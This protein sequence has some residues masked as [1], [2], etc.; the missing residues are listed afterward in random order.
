MSN[1]TPFNFQGSEIR[2]VGTADKPEWVAADII[3][4]LYPDVRARD[5]ANYLRRIPEEWKGSTQVYDSGENHREESNH[6]SFMVSTKR[7]SPSNGQYRNMVTVTEPGLYHLIFRSDSPLAVPFQRWV[8]EDVLPS[9][10]K[11]GG[12]GSTTAEIKLEHK[13]L[14]LP[15]AVALTDAIQ[16]VGDYGK[17][18]M[19]VLNEVCKAINPERIE[20]T[21]LNPDDFSYQKFIHTYNGVQKYMQQRDILADALLILPLRLE[22][23]QESMLVYLKSNPGRKAHWAEFATEVPVMRKALEVAFDV[24]WDCLTELKRDKDKA[25]VDHNWI[26]LELLVKAILKRL[27]AQGYGQLKNQFFHLN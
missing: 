13:V 2:L 15:E 27:E 22:E 7:S 21:R 24:G 23:M 6:N 8:F 10:R 26:H 16:L 1:I 19:T 12:Y 5:R 14:S 25:G 9:I 18:P 3:A 20:A 4:I 17:S 11:T